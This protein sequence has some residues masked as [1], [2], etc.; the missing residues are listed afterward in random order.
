LFITRSVLYSLE[1]KFSVWPLLIVVA[2]IDNSSV[3]PVA[4][5][6]DDAEVSKVLGTYPF[7]ELLGSCANTA[8]AT[9]VIARNTAAAAFIDA[10]QR[11]N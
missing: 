5:F 6:V 1:E 3:K 4:E 11:K 10:M 7:V 9:M 2:F 8:D